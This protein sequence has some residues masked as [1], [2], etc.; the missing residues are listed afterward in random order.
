MNLTSVLIILIVVYLT[1]SYVVRRS[2]IF[3]SSLSP[4]EL[5]NRLTQTDGTAK[6]IDVRSVAEYRGG[7]I[8]TAIN[9]PH[10]LIAGQPPPVPRDSTIILYCETGSRSLTAK[11]VLKRLGFKNVTNFGSVGR[12][13]GPLVTG[14]DPGEMPQN[15]QEG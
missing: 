14:I 9:I 10:D 6:L 15:E 4:A 3:S 12:W 1:G 8:P 11:A 2:G 13:K 7:H 5:K